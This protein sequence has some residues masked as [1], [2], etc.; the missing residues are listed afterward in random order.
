MSRERAVRVR[1]R[2][3]Y[4]ECGRLRDDPHAA[5]GCAEC[6]FLDGRP[7]DRV[8]AAVI[9]HLRLVGEAPCT[10]LIVAA[11]GKVT[12]SNRRSMLR[13]TAALRKSGR[14]A[15]RVGGHADREH[16]FRLVSK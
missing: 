14:L 6:N 4:C 15:V 8:K 10:E 1:D 2:S 7:K 16:F 13:S 11:F 12:E 3:Q 9:E 5:E